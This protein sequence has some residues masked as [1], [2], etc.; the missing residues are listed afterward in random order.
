MD[1]ERLDKGKQTKLVHVLEGIGPPQVSAG[2]VG[3]N[4]KIVMEMRNGGD[5]P[6]ATGQGTC[7]ETA[8]VVDE[9]GDDH[10]NDLLRKPGGGGHVRRGGLRRKTPGKH[11]SDYG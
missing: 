5:V 9:I 10:V 4:E 2:E 7:T 6:G 1:P 3:V 11:P 8:H